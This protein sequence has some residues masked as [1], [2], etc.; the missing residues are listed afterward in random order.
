[1]T[2]S[3][4]EHYR[5]HIQRLSARERRALSLA[6]TVLLG[7]GLVLAAEALFAERARLDRQLPAL[8][9]NL[10]SMEHDAAEL[11]RLRGRPAVQARLDTAALLA[12]ARARGISADV[13]SFG[14]NQFR[15][16]GQGSLPELLPWLADLHAEYGLRVVE[17]QFSPAPASRYT[18]VLGQGAH[19]Q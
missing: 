18:L 14:N 10:N 12:S 8:A 6:L 3:L 7:A 13:Q 17:M 1:M 4:T 16:D 5:R 9:R 2:N 11:A 19:S 15:V